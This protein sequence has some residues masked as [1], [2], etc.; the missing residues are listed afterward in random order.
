MKTSVPKTVS[1]AYLL[2]Y[3][4]MHVSKTILLIPPN[5]A[6]AILITKLAEAI[7]LPLLRSNQYHGAT[8]DLEPN[9]VS[10][11]KKTGCEEVIVVEL[12]GKKTEEK[13]QNLGIKLTIIDHHHYTNLDRAHGPNGKLL[14]SSLEQFLKMFRLTDAKL[15]KLG[16]VP[17]LVKGIGILDRGFVWALLE[18]GYSKKEMKSVLKFHDDLTAPL[19]DPKTEARKQKTVEAIW[20]K[21]KAWNGYFI[22][23][24]NADLSLRP[25]VSRLIATEIGKPTSLIIIERKR[26]LIYVQESKHA[27]N[28]F[29]TFGGFTFGLDHNWGYR[30]EKGKKQIGLKEVKEVLCA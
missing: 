8:L 29:K 9:I 16:F 14:P 30:N 18:E 1:F 15:T 4:R 28:L 11:I 26:N 13:I 7:G 21:R 23:E 24:T 6:E 12:P 17:R 10:R 19:H 2:Y 5:D 20:K 3:S 22:L 25:R 27:M